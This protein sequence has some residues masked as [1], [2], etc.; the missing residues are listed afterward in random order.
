MRVELDDVAQSFGKH[1]LFKGLTLH[2]KSGQ[3]TVV[4]AGNGAGKSTLLQIMAGSR[5][6]RFGNV[7]WN[8]TSLQEDITQRPAF[9]SPYTELIEDVTLKEHLRFQE[10]FLPWHGGLHHQD[11]LEATGLKEQAGKAIKLFSSGMKQRLRLSLALLSSAQAILLDEPV[12]N[13]DPA[14]MDWYARLLDTHLQGRTL[15]VA[16]NFNEREYP[17]DGWVQIALADFQP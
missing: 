1:T 7:S 5:S 3:K 11:V 14:G 4:L 10:A 17:G 13:L 8:G 9:A 6:P 16:S 15:V 12:S 2:L